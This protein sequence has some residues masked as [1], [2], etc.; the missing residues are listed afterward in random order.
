MKKKTSLHIFF[1]DFRQ[2]LSYCLLFFLVIISWKGA[3]RFNERVCF[4]DGDGF[5]FKWRVHPIAGTAV[6]IG[7]FSKKLQDR[8]DAPACPPPLWE[9]LPPQLGDFPLTLFKMLVSG[10]QHVGKI[11]DLSAG[12][13]LLLPLVFNAL[14]IEASSLQKRFFGIVIT[15]FNFQVCQNMW[16]SQV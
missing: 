16:H 5:I 12:L 13:S 10:S 4:S 11:L 2:I 8:G 15:S 14:S 7:R 9:T 6:L 1:K 3:S